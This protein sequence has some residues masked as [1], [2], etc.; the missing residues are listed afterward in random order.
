MVKTTM[1]VELGIPA[2]SV[3]PAAAKQL[4]LDDVV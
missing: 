3:C 4:Y 1:S 2:S